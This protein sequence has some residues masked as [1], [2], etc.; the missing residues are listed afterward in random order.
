MMT[1]SLNC[2]EQPLL[3]ELSKPTSIFVN[4][5]WARFCATVKALTFSIAS[6][7]APSV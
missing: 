6:W 2:S 4:P 3:I 1:D 7:N 5:R